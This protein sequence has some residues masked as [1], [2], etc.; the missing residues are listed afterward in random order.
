[1]ARVLWIFYVSKVLE[2]IDTFM[3]AIKQQLPSDHVPPLVSSHVDLHHLVD[4]SLLRA[5]RRSVLQ[6]GIELVRAR[7]HVRLLSLVDVSPL[8]PSDVRDGTDA[9]FYRP[10]ITTLQMTQF[11]LMLIQATYDLFVPNPYPR[12]CVWILFLYMFTM[13]GLFANFFIQQYTKPAKK[14]ETSKES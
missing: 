2:F 13:L 4:H 1:M 5:R 7:R 3:M 11:T 12:F 9:A 8:G 6:C 10:Y 14:K